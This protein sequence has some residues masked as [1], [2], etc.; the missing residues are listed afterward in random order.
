MPKDVEKEISELR[1]AIQRHDR[2]YYVEAAPKISDF[3]YDRLMQRLR[4]LESAHPD[5][6]APDSP[7][8]RVG[9]EPIDGFRTVDHTRPMYSI[10]N[11][12]DAESLRKWVRRCFEALDPDIARIESAL[13]RIDA[14][15]TGLVGKRGGDTTRLREN[16]KSQRNELRVRLEAILAEADRNGFPIAGGLVA[17]PK[18]DG[19]AVDI[20]Y[21]RGKLALALTRGDGRRGDDITQNVRT[22]RAIPLRLTEQHA[23]PIPNVLEI[24]GEIFMPDAEFERLNAVFERTGEEPFANPRNAT[25]GTLKQLEPRVVAERKLQFI[26]HGH[27]EISGKP[28]AKHSEFIKAVSAWG[29]PSN[30]LIKHCRSV[31]EV[32]AVIEQFESQ[33]AKLPYGVDGMVVK[34]DRIDLQEQLGYTSRFPRWAI[35]YKYAAEQAVTKLLSVEWQVGKTGKVTPRAT[36]DPVLIAGTT[37]T[38]ATLHNAG[39]ICRKDIR[40]GD[41]VVIEKAGEIIPQVVRVVRDKRPRGLPPIQPPARCPECGGAIEVEFDQRRQQAIRAWSERTGSDPDRPGEEPERLSGC[42]ETG[43]YCINPEC[44]AQ[45]RE[46]LIHFVGRRQMDLD[47]FGDKLIVQL[48]D[49]GL[50][51]GFADLYRLAAPDLI[52]LERTDTWGP[53]RA[54]N[55]VANIAASTHR[56]LARF[57]FGLAIPHLGGREAVAI[58]REYQILERLRKAKAERIHQTCWIGMAQAG[59]VQRFLESDF[60][61]EVLSGLKDL[62]ITFTAQLDTDLDRRQLEKKGP[63]DLPY[64]ASMP[65]AHVRARLE[66]FASKAAMD[67]QGLGTKAIDQLILDCKVRTYPDLYRLDSEQLAALERPVKMSQKQAEKLLENIA[68]SKERGL[69][70]LLGAL[71]IRHVGTHVARILAN[72]FSSIDALLNA[73]QDRMSAIMEIGDITARSI[74]DFLHSDEGEKTIN[75]LRLAGVRMTAAE[76]QGAVSEVFQGKT[77]VVTGTLAKYTRDQVHALI[78]QHGG[79]TATSVS[80]KTDFVLAG[81][82]AGSKLTLAKELGVQILSEDAFDKL[83]QNPSGS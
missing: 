27:G 46:R 53:K 64:A 12:Y 75:E 34:I 24:R 73:D 65:V 48:I 23:M 57:L 6:V 68:K 82:Q 33:R 76:P 32:W 81:D 15:E 55:L 20:R 39:E 11:T 30:R 47:G 41:T 67:I 45:L 58:A 61:Q 5:L 17:E 22:I 8:Q 7:T 13:R 59:A 26:A 79:R 44:R 72:A 19:V 66:H 63:V 50:V 78:R 2:L 52:G 62:D 54:R 4:D 37:V 25:A 18:I 43:R 9:G 35:A 14:E 21:E 38:H 16:L 74:Y 70:R 29:I 36:M 56:G 1:A 3:E 60:F 10:D 69:A 42:D 31:D 51:S 83:V 77:I 40:I 71:G 80:K 49:R 28:F